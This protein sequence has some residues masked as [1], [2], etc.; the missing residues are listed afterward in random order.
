MVLPILNRRGPASG[1]TARL[2][3][4]FNKRTAVIPQLM[5]RSPVAIS[6]IGTP[7]EPAASQ[8]CPI[9]L[10]RQKRISRQTERHDEREREQ[11]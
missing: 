9:L 8:E 4:R 2:S 6:S 10:A 7:A 5:G 1:T 11:Q 3:K